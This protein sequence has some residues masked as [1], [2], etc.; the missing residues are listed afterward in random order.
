MKQFFAAWILIGG[1][2]APTMS[3]AADLYVQIQKDIGIG[4]SSDQVNVSAAGSLRAGSILA[5]PEQF[6]KLNP[7]SRQIDLGKTLAAWAADFAPDRVTPRSFVYRDQTSAAFFPVRVARAA[8]GSRLGTEPVKWIALASLAKTGNLKIVS[9]PAA[10]RAT[11]KREVPSEAT[12]KCVACTQAVPGTQTAQQDAQQILTLLNATASAS[13]ALPKPPLARRGTKPAYRRP[14]MC[15]NIINEEGRIGTWGQD[16]AHIMFEPRYI[17][18]FFKSNALGKFCPKFNQL[19]TEMKTRAWLWFWATLAEKE[20]SCDPKKPH[21]T[22]YYN[23]ATRR[24]E[25]LNPTPG[26][27]LWAM[28]KDVNLRRARGPACYNIRTVEGQ[29]RCSIDIMNRRQLRRNHT[30]SSDAESYWGP[31]R[32]G[33][34]QIM[35]NMRRFQPCF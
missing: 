10:P 3:R 24:T 31:V 33:D 30:A 25:R 20:S 5:I 1:L 22:H 12:M 11:A 4:H 16:I 15:S 2:F 29:A 14:P 8:D 6:V 26:W 27:G 17:G 19:S 21:S 28:E 18:G 34:Q 13:N 9:P 32:R 7:T 35:P 23:R